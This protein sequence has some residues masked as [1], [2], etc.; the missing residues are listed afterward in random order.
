[1]I[2]KKKGSKKMEIIVYFDGGHLMTRICGIAGLPKRETRVG[3]K[4]ER[5]L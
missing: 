2:K 1:M 4:E 3:Q 5:A